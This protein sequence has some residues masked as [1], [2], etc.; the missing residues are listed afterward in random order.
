MAMTLTEVAVEVHADT[1]KLKPQ[2]VKGAREAG[3]AAGDALGDGLTRGVDGKLRDDK[4]R[5]VAGGAGA[6]KKFAKGFQGEM[7]SGGTF[8][9]V[10]AVMASKFA[11]IGGAAAAAAPGI[12]QLTAALVPAAGAALA[13]P[14]AL[15]SVQAAS[16]TVKIAVMGVGD[17]IKAGFGDNAEKAEKALNALSGNARKFAQETIGLKDSL[18]GVQRAVADRFFLPFLDDV[19]PLA[20]LYIPMLKREMADLAGPLGGLAEQFAETGR[21]GLIFQTVTKVFEQTRLAA[22]NVRGA[23]DPLAWSLAL[24]VKDTVGELPGL[25][26]GFSA[27]SERFADFVAHASETGAITQAFRNGVIVLKDLGGIIGNVGSIIASVYRAA[28]ANGNTLLANLRELTAQA[29]AFF[30]T[31]QGADALRAVFGTLGAFGAALRT[32]LGAVLPA[33]AE[34]LKSLGPA[35]AGLAGPAAQLIVAIAPLLPIVAGIA[36]TIITKLTPAIAALAGWLAQNETAVK[37]IAIALVAFAAIL[38]VSAA[39][40]A[41]QAAGGM[42]AWVKA[43]RIATVA[44]KVF[45]AVQY[46]LGV[47]MR[48]ALGPIGLIITAIGLLVA[49]IV[50]AWKNHEGFRNVVMKVWDA[51]KKAVAATVDWFVGTAWPFLQK[52]WKGI[53]DG[54]VAMWN[55]G[56]KPVVMALVAFWQNVLAPTA[57]WLWKNVIQPVFKG[58]AAVVKV[59]FAVVQLAV[60]VAVAYFKNV[61]APVAMWLWKNII[62]PAFSG[63][64]ATVRVMMNVVKAILAGIVAYF[65]NVLAPVYTWLWRNIVVPVFNGIRNTISNVWNNG[66]KPVLQAVGNFIKNTVAP[67]FKNGVDAISKAWSA[68]KNAAMTPVRFVVN[69]V[70]NPLIGGFNAV[71]RVFGT[72]QVD[73]ISGFAEGG[74]IPGSPSRRDNRMAAMT[75]GHGRPIGTLKVATG[76]YVVNSASTS[77][78]LPVLEAINKSRG[79]GGLGGVDP[80]TDGLADGGIVGWAQNLIGKAKGAA[81]GLFDMVTNP[82]EALKKIAEAAINKIPGGGAIRDMLVGAGRTIVSKAVEKLKGMFAMSGG[83]SFGNWP[84][85]PSAQRGDSGVWR[86][87]VAMIRSTG[88]ISG[89]FGNGYRPGDPKWHGSGRAVDWMGY[90]Q[91]ALASMLAARRP[92]ELIHRT[93]RRDYAYTRGK[94]KGSFSS[95]LMEAH[96]NHIHIA[97][98][99][100]GLMAPVAKVASADFGSVTLARG[101]NL[102]HNGLG[103]TEQLVDPTAGGAGPV[104]W[105]PA[106]LESLGRIIA[107]EMATAVGAGNYAAGRRVGLYTRGG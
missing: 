19:R 87:I 21:R 81:T 7:S 105:H 33:V 57:M 79:G 52:V 41:V 86:R 17:A 95:G 85:S 22:I 3:D 91:D 56:I 35:I 10:A 75:D 61:L 62:Q 2:V 55:N 25:A 59:A 1:K 92:L 15:L 29:A 78:W 103:R 18:T 60:A 77:R 84:S 13:L 45:T 9:K 44:T 64:A 5:F 73:K 40:A 11:L 51:I 39:V 101:N 104:R 93:G 32:S 97:M 54:A 96:R 30:K 88:P 23:I 6:A 66:I 20:N 74:R 90:N 4:G 43:T 46:A 34:S 94:N 38:K 31:A 27:A 100:G 68:L 58:I 26:K 16:A 89:A 70:I 8:G 72:T 80:R 63:I 107:R 28:T 65:R 98:A 14:A 67:A 53:A 42:L 106:D 82:G 99:K 37:S 102:I 76:E 71:A 12:G 83:G 47:A 24:L 36:A 50:Y 69:S 49:G 48:F